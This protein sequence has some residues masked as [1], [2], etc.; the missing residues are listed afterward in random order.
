LIG[1]IQKS[2][3]S[4]MSAATQIAATSRQQESLVHEYGASTNEA[5]AA[6]QKIQVDSRGGGVVPSALPVT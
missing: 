5:A 3:I 1:K 6:V 2:S 4:L